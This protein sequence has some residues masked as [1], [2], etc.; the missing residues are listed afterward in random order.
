MLRR[1]LIAVLPL[2]AAGPALA[3]G[4]EKKAEARDVGQYVDLSS[5]AIPIIAGG[6]VVNYVFV[7]VRIVLTS[8]ANTPKLRAK[9]PY[10]R[11][12]LVR[13]AHRTPFT[14]STDYLSVD[15]TK[16]QSTLMREAVAIAGPNNIKGVVITSQTPKRRI[17]MPNPRGRN[18]GGEIRP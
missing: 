8:S 11:D 5:V 13:A 10:F 9:E 14:S 18:G 3:S 7:S 17:G 2:L 16:L 12:A 15:A 6:Q 4:G 1:A